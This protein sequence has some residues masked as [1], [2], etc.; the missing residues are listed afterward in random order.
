MNASSRAVADGEVVHVVMPDHAPS[1]DPAHPQNLPA[2]GTSREWTDKGMV[3]MRHTTEIGAQQD[4]PTTV[5][6]YSVYLHLKS[7]ALTTAPKAGGKKGETEKRPPKN[8]D[9]LYRKDLLGKAGQIYGQH[10]RIHFEICCDP[11]SLQRLLGAQRTL[12]WQSD[13]AP[14]TADGRTDALFGSTCI[15]LPVGT[16][17]HHAEPMSHLRAPSDGA[18]QTATE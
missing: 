11:A 6:F 7:L 2:Y 13:S 10:G 3:I 12:S 15:Y 8:G 5:T 14:P 4:V 16:P 17:L 1:A 9:R 18:S